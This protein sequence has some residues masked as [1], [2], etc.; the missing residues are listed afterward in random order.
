MGKGRSLPISALSFCYN[1]KVRDLRKRFWDKVNRQ[2]PTMSHMD[3]PCWQWTAGTT[4]DGY[5]RFRIDKTRRVLAHVF[6]Y[7]SEIHTKTPGFVLDH[8]CRNPA[9]VNPSHLREVTNKQNCENRSGA[10]SNNYSSRFRGVSWHKRIGRWQ[11]RVR[12]DGWTYRAGYFD[13]E[14]EAAIAVRELRNRL[15]THNDVDRE[16]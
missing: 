11:G 4:A 12:H 3:T 7:E 10:S 13:T 15:H 16:D 2:G 6:S 5:G 1:S 8:Q 9:C 14:E